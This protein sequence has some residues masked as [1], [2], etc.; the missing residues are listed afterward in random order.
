MSGA[1]KFRPDIGNDT[2]EE[3]TELLTMSDLA[4]VIIADRSE[5]A[6]N[7]GAFIRVNWEYCDQYEKRV[8]ECRLIEHG[9]QDYQLE[10]NELGDSASRTYMILGDYVTE[11]EH[12]K[13]TIDTQAMPASNEVHNRDAK[14]FLRAGYRQT[15]LGL[16]SEEYT[17]T[18]F[19]LIT[20][21]MTVD[22]IKNL[23][24][25]HPD[26]LRIDTLSA[27]AFSTDSGKG[28]RAVRELHEIARRNITMHSNAE[29]FIQAFYLSQQSEPLPIN[30]IASIPNI[31]LDIDKK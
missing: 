3:I 6:V 14:K 30:H 22:S 17:E 18:V 12:D 4:A 8:F 10:V 31:H 7:E 25:D 5:Q 20:G 23:R 9:H 11:F 28:G 15:D 29:G 13:N 19:G 21:M 1:E 24:H 26:R 2:I 27:E 16:R